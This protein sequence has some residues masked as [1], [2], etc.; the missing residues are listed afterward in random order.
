MNKKTFFVTGTDTDAGKTVVT[1]GLL[2]GAR[3][4]G[5][6][7]LGLKPLSA[8][9][10]VTPDGLRN[11]DALEIMHAMTCELPYE[12]VNPAAF[13]S[14]AAPHI[15][16]EQTNI[17]VTLEQLTQWCKNTQTVSANITLIEGA[18][19]WR[20]PIN[21]Q[22]MLSAL[23][24][25]LD[26]PVILVVGM[27]LG[28]LNHATLT[29]EAIMRDGIKIAGWVA[30]RIDPDML[31]YEE[32]LKTL[33]RLIPAPCLGNIPFLEPVDNARVASYLNLSILTD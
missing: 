6:K 8:G 22:H 21:T 16:A 9:C 19:G 23:P 12:Q 1:C 14:P 20:V 25:E 18:G 31:Y 32:N 5:Y 33:H 10:E 17:T 26:I 27:K 2:E 7:T 29:A 13:E 24:K 30:N 11:N 28:C 15:V 4:K 3:M